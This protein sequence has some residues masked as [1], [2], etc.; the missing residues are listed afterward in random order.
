MTD[1]ARRSSY[2]R[3]HIAAMGR[4]IGEGANVIGY[5]CWSLLDNFE[6]ADG[7]GPRFG[8]VEVDYATQERRPRG[9]ARM[10]AEICKTNRVALDA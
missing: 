3:R 2:L 7:Y 1:D 10:Y 5:C 6:W 4:A 9:S 8:I